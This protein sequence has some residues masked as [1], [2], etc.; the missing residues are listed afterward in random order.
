MVSAQGYEGLDFI[1]VVA[2]EYSWRYAL[3]WSP[4]VEAWRKAAR[5]GRRTP[6]IARLRLPKPYDLVALA[7]V[8]ADLRL[9]QHGAGA[10]A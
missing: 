2:R 6:S 4:I 1:E 9:R 3:P 8:E 10:S 7:Q 5:H